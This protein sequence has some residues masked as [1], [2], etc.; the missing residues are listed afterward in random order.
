M[1]TV[2]NL[3]CHVNEVTVGYYLPYSIGMCS[4]G[5]SE[6]QALGESLKFTSKLHIIE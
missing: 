5:V 3:M 4:L 2:V 6:V 1:C